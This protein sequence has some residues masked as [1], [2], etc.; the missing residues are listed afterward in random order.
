MPKS[1]IPGSCTPW[2]GTATN[3][4]HWLQS[5]KAVAGIIHILHILQMMKGVDAE[6]VERIFNSCD[7]TSRG[8]ISEQDLRHALR[9]AKQPW[10]STLFST[11]FLTG[12]NVK[13]SDERN[14]LFSEAMGNLV[15]CS[16]QS[17]INRE[18]RHSPLPKVWR[19]ST[20]NFRH[21]VFVYF[22]ARCPFPRILGVAHLR[23]EGRVASLHTRSAASAPSVCPSV[24]RS[25]A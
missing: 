6:Q 12:I 19:H 3:T 7:K 11:R 14:E 18:S 22:F 23:P 24:S 2:Q 21:L 10:M 20:G 15:Y 13:S 16:T 25:A 9:K 17:Y 8:K 5:C 1:V 4:Y